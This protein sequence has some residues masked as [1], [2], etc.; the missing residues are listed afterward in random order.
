RLRSAKDIEMTLE[1]LMK[2]PTHYFGDYK[3]AFAA[4]SKVY[5]EKQD[6]NPEFIARLDA[7]AKQ[8]RIEQ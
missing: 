2:I 3:N 8:N 5:R 4:Y 1:G 7:F 6:A